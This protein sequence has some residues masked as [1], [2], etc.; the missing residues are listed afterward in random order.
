[1]DTKLK[2]NKNVRVWLSVLGIFLV[3]FG[4]LCLFPVIHR[5]AQAQLEERK[6]KQAKE[7]VGAEDIN[8]DFLREL[9]E[10]CYVL[11]AE[12]AEHQG[13]QSA[14][15]VYVDIS[16]R[17]EDEVSFEEE[18]KAAVNNE[19]DAMSSEFESYRETIDYCIDLGEERYLTNTNQPLKL[20]L[21]KRRTT[22][23]VTRLKQYYNAYFLF[24][25]DANGIFS[26]E[27]LYNSFDNSDALIKVA[28][29]IA[30]ET[31][32]WGDVNNQYYGAMNGY[33]TKKPTDFEVLFAI[34]KT[35]EYQ[36]V[37]ED[38]E[39]G[40]DYWLMMTIYRKAGAQLLYAGALGLLVI[41]AFVMTSGRIWSCEISMNRPRK[42]YF[43]EIAGITV[44]CVLAFTNS[45]CQM[46]WSF[47]IHTGYDALAAQMLNGEGMADGI[48]DILGLAIPVFAVYVIWYLAVLFIRPLFTLGVCEYVRQYSLCYQLF[49]FLRS[50]KDKLMEELNHI[51]FGKK[52]TVT[53]LKFLT[54]NFIVMSLCAMCR[55][56]GIPL[57]L[58][59][60][61]VLFCFIE[62]YCRKVGADYQ[63]LRAGIAQMAEGD[64]ETE[65]TED[66]GIFQS[67]KEDLGKVRMGFK[68]A[69]DEEVKS[70]RMKTELI[71]NVSHDL[72]TPLTAITT[73]VELLKKE[74][75]TEEERC[76]YIETLEQKSLRLKVLIE[77]LFEVSKATS[78]SIILTYM[79]VDVVKLLKQVHVE[80]TEKFEKL[81]LDLRWNVPTDKVMVQL[82]SQKTYRIFENLFVNIGKYAMPQSRVYIEVK[83]DEE[84]VW[85]ILKNMSANALTISGEEI[86]ERFV[87]GDASRNT[88]GS[89]LGLAI[90]K[91]FTEAQGGSFAVEVDGDLFKVVIGFKR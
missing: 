52:T 67:V 9:Y 35:A 79:E 72:K 60:S 33:H 46:I 13:V 71:T 78:N 15:D 56:I 37:Q 16:A 51:D 80:H 91:S 41:L 90:A 42:W 58:V 26:V 82:D 76:S 11:Y 34:P 6:E 73:Y 70:Q 5:E 2:S 3:T 50:V 29:Q 69:V 20:L 61:I 64:L 22:S 54:V 12:A 40:Q 75:I 62:R 25:F 47:D 53:S 44:V 39:A 21:G 8:Y 55:F 4:S 68:K 1:M 65:I 84:Q 23:E 49:L 31:N 81:G 74:D 89:G 36:L 86:T 48:Y 63:A 24:Q 28:Q 45:F 14:F 17:S 38:Y 43:M 10:G 32:V 27:P 87:R 59:Y 30:R 7:A 85:V 83:I 57:L 19:Y 77:D 66:L 88:D 18:F